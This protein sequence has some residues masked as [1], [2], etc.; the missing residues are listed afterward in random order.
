MK[1]FIGGKLSVMTSICLS[2][3]SMC[4]DVITGSFGSGLGDASWDPK[5]NKATWISLNVF[6]IDS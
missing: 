1:F 2:S 5:M 6:L 3:P 4:A